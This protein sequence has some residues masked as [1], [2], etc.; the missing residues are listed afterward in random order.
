MYP[1]IYYIINIVEHTA[2]ANTWVTTGIV[3]PEVTHERSVLAADGRTESVIPRVEGLRTDGVL[4]SHIDSWLLAVG[5]AVLH[6][7]HVAVE[8]DVL[9][10]SPLTRAVVNHD[11]T[12]GVATER[13]LTVRYQ[14][15]TT[16]ETHVTDNDVV[17]VYLE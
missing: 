6:I 7:E 12:H 17:G 16:T 15:L 10:E 2:P 5:L 4:D 8:G 9:V 1:V 14:C 13:V 3:C 11:V